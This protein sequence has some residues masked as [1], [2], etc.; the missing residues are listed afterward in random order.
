MILAPLGL[1]TDIGGSIRIPAA[2]TCLDPKLEAHTD[3][4]T[5]NG[6]FGLRPSTGRLPYEGMANSMD[7]QNSILSVVGPLAS[8]A[9]S[10]RLLT[11]TVLSQKPWLFDPLVHEIPWRP[12]H[13]AFIRENI[14]NPPSSKAGGKLSFGLFRTDGIVNPTPPI[15]RAMDTLVKALTAAGHEIIDWQPPSHR[16]IQDAGFKSWIYDSG[17]DVCGAFALSGEPMSPQIAFFQS[18]DQVF[19]GG[20]IA[21]NNVELRR[22]RKEYL[23]YW[24]GTVAHTST[25][26]PVDAVIC[27]LAP[28]PAARREKY[29][30][31]GYSTWVNTL[32]YTAVTVPVTVVRK[33]VDVREE[34]YVPIDARDQKVQDDCKFLR[35]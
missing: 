35:T 25:G 13:E 27:P 12:D 4:P 5:V 32:D 19:T 21:A 9:A 15:T 34:G 17:D 30:Y 22:L 33:E 20:E 14:P 3:L 8:N 7:G 31:Y 24:T 11:Q 29:S 23:D 16:P 2:C 10:L 1:G 6:L 28:W 18:L 26:R